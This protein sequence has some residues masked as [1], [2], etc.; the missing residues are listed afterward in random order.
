MRDYTKFYID[1]KWVAPSAPRSL[2]VINPANEEVAG[3]ISLG[4]LE[5]AVGE[6]FPG[7]VGEANAAAAR[8]AFRTLSARSSRWARKYAVS[9]SATGC[10]AKVT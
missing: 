3:R 10:P 1:G 6:R 5:K 9:R 2:D 7:P 4:A 8:A